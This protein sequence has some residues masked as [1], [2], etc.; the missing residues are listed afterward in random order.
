MAGT[1]VE[2]GTHPTVAIKIAY[3]GTTIAELYPEAAPITVE[4]FLTLVDGNSMMDSPST[5]SAPV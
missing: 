3:D 5:A 2:P 4:N 1:D